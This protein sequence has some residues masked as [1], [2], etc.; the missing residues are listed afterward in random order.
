MLLPLENALNPPLLPA[1]GVLTFG[2]APLG[3]DL[4]GERRLLVLDED[5]TTLELTV[6][7]ALTPFPNMSPLKD[8][9]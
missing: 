4:S 9:T 8:V 2:V 5:T 1:L 3:D 7:L 6:A